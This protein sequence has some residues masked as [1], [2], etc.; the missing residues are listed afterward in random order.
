MVTFGARLGVNDGS[1]RR[2]RLQFTPS[3]VVWL[4]VVGERL[5]DLTG[6]QVVS[7]AGPPVSAARGR[8]TFRLEENGAGI[9]V[10]LTVDGA[11]ATLVHRLL[12]DGW[13]GTVEPPLENWTRRRRWWPVALLGLAAAWVGWPAWRVLVSEDAATVASSAGAGGCGVACILSGAGV[14]AAISATAM[15]RDRFTSVDRRRVATRWPAAIGAVGLVFAFLGAQLAWMARED[16]IS[17]LIGIFAAIMGIVFAV[18]SC[19]V[20]VRRVSRGIKIRNLEYTL[21]VPLG[22]SVERREYDDTP[23][24]AAPV[25][26]LDN[27]GEVRVPGLATYAF[28]DKWTRTTERHIGVLRAWLKDDDVPGEPTDD[29]GRPPPDPGA[30]EAALEKLAR[31]AVTT[32]EHTFGAPATNRFLERNRVRR[33]RRA[34]AGGQDVAFP[35]WAIGTARY[36]RRPPD[37]YFVVTA[38][39]RLYTC[40][41]PD[42]P[43]T[44]RDVP[45]ERIS[46]L[47]TRVGNRWDDY[48]LRVDWLLAECLDGD[49]P[50][51]LACHRE[52]MPVLLSV[53]NRESPQA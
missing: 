44:R 18:R 46:V 10:E 8:A 24:L 38:D 51:L 53:L 20:G 6:H 21:F 25:V 1:S 31:H 42:L 49:E 39:G 28:L 29:S 47:R 52:E 37:G 2:G 30:K 17:V 15:W 43:P 36:C 16:T 22:L 11:D 45:V 26:V 48:P 14:L 9:T 12:R 4:P 41:A 3:R 19:F 7:M 35:G 33:S 34:L 40:I 23:T 13:E 50:L 27:G 32:D 5:V